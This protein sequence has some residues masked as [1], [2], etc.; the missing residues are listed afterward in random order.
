LFAR[1][2]ETSYGKTRPHYNSTEWGGGMGVLF[3]LERKKLSMKCEEG[4]RP[5]LIVCEQIFLLGKRDSFFFSS[6]KT[7]QAR[8]YEV[9]SN[10]DVFCFA[11]RIKIV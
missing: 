6:S 1:V 5:F 11:W 4:R 10:Q 2:R 7:F 8:Y 9:M 3:Y